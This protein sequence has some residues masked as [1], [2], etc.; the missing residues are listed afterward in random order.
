[1]IE[2]QVPKDITTYKTKTVGPLTMRQLQ[3]S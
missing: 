3:R 2:I 1:M